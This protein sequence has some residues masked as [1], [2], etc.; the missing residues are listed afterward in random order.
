ML[1]NKSIKE[2]STLLKKKE[3][4]SVDLADLILSCNTR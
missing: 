3:I 2:L 4:S 1:I